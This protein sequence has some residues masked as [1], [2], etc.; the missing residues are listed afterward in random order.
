MP[1]FTTDHG[2]EYHVDGKTLIWPPT[3]Y[4]G[5]P[6]PEYIRLPLRMKLK[7]AKEA[8]TSLHDQDPT[9]PK[10]ISAAL[11]M[12]AP[13]KEEQLDELDVTEIFDLFDAWSF[14]YEQLTGVSL[15]EPSTPPSS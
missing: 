2:H 9:D 8:V 12:I 10:V 14:Q 11:N 3:R 1:T 13:G 4:E 5:E 6:E 7:T 15:G